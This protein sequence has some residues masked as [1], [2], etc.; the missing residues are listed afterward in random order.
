VQLSLSITSFIP[1]IDACLEGRLPGGSTPVFISALLVHRSYLCR[2]ISPVS[3]AAM[4][5]TMIGFP[6]KLKLERLGR[7]HTGPFAL[8]SLLLKE[9]AGL[10]ICERRPS[11]IDESFSKAI[12]PAEITCTRASIGRYL[13]ECRS[14]HSHARRRSTSQ[15]R[16]RA[17]KTPSSPDNIP[18]SA[19][20]SHGRAL[21]K[22]LPLIYRNDCKRSAG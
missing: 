11:R 6:V 14:S 4:T 21:L 10:A 22:E 3:M 7:V 12:L 2:R 5:P 16:R 8:G 15:C 13:R 19:E 1:A 17:G 9:Q 18:L 20:R